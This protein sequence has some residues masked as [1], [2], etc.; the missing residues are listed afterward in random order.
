MMA[1]NGL[2]DGVPQSEHCRGKDAGPR[3]GGEMKTVVRRSLR[4]FRGTGYD[5]GRPIVVQA[6]WFAFMNLV[7]MKWWLPASWRVYLLRAFGSEVGKNVLI[8]HRVR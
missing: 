2:D 8:R 7:F 3:L 5:K 6:L 4:D 1:E